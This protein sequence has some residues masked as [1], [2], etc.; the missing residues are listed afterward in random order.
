MIQ[1][2]HMKK[3]QKSKIAIG[4]SLHYYCVINIESIKNKNKKAKI[5]K[6]YIC[7]N[8]DLEKKNF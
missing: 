8:R 3:K 7:R 1:S 2:H 6:W 4:M 5:I